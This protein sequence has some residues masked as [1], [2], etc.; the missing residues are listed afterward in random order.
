MREKGI[1]GGSSDATSSGHPCGSD[2]AGEEPRDSSNSGGTAS[3]FEPNKKQKVVVKKQGLRSLAATITAEN[4]A[5]ATAIRD[6]GDSQMRAELAKQKL[7]YMQQED[8]RRREKYRF[9]M[10]EKMQ[11]NIRLLRTDLR[12]IEGLPS[13]AENEAARNSIEREIEALEKK[14][15]E[16]ATELGI[17]SCFN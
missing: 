13:S 2:G 6:Y 3:D 5:I 12:E 15:N 10:W 16:L 17:D 1:G 8:S 14:K 11:S 4:N 7:L 9:T